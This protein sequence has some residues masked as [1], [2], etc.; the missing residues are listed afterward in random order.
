MRTTLRRPI[1][2]IAVATALALTACGQEPSVGDPAAAAAS[3]AAAFPTTVTTAAGDVRIEAEP[4]AIV[5]LGATAT[6]MLF[7]IGAG[8]QVKAVDEHSNYPTAA[9]TTDLSSYEP[10]VEAVIALAP[11]LVVVTSDKGGLGEQLGAADIPVMVLPAAATLD[12]VYDQFEQLGQAT[13]H[14]EQ[15]GE[16][17]ADVRSRLERIA[18][19]TPKPDQPVT[20]YHE[21]T[22]D[23]YSVTSATFVGQVFGLLGMRSIADAAPGGTSENG[24]YPQL[25]A[26]YVVKADPDVIFLADTKCCQQTPAAVAKRPGWSS[27]SAVENERVIALDDDVASRWGP[28]V[29]ELLEAAAEALATMTP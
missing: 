4:D 7:A 17:A 3:G 8:D 15:A 24:G 16:V 27:I 12:E 14:R 23:H 5:S 10:N 1:T 6:E 13:G 18:R 28:R 29:V 11:D 9:P 25:S 19:Q 26:E 22:P 20:Y 21:L 2:A